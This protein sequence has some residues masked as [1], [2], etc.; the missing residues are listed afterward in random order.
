MECRPGANREGVFVSFQDWSP[1]PPETR[2]NKKQK[3]KN[4]NK[5]K[6]KQKKQKQNK[7]SGEW[8]GMV[9]H[10]VTDPDQVN[11]RFPK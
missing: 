2:K 8:Q 10:T 4:K 5:T 3:Q 1:S 6:T 11:S 7:E 9:E